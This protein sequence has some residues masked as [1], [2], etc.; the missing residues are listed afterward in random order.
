[1][2]CGRIRIRMENGK[3]VVEK[4]IEGR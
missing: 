1:M 2:E 3:P 4:F